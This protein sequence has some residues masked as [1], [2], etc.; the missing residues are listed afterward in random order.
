MYRSHNRRRSRFRCYGVVDSATSLCFVPDTAQQRGFW[1]S[2]QQ[3]LNNCNSPPT[4]T[5]KLNI[6]TAIPFVYTNWYNK[7]PDCST[8]LDFCAQ[9][10]PGRS[11]RWNDINCATKMCVLCEYGPF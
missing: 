10:W 11:S 7:Q 1:T 6:N 5:W 9:L 4:F 3:L 8:S 2:G